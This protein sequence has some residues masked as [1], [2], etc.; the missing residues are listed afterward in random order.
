[1]K[2]KALQMEFL[3]LCGDYAAC[4]QPLGTLQETEKKLCTFSFVFRNVKLQLVYRPRAVFGTPVSTLYC[5][6]FPDKNSPVWLHLPQLLPLLGISDYRACYFPYIETAKRMEVCFRALTSFFEVLYPRL[7]ALAADG[8]DRTLLL[9]HL[10]ESG[11]SQTDAEQVLRFGTPEQQGYLV[12]QN[13]NDTTFVARFTEWSPWKCYLLGQQDKAQRLYAKQKLL[14]YEYGLLDFLQTA[15]G[16]SFVPMQPECFAV[17]DMQAVTSGTEDG[18]TLFKGMLLLYPLCA[19]AGCALMGLL[20]MISSWGTLCWFGPE[21]YM[22]L[23]LGA[24][25]A[26][27][28]G[29][30]LRRQ[31][32]PIMNRKNAAA[33]LEFDDILNGGAVNRFT[34]GTFYAFTAVTMIFALLM[35]GQTVRL[36]EDHGD[37]DQTVFSREVFSYEQIDRVYHIEARY[38]DYGERIERDSYVIALKDGRLIDLDG[39]T[40]P[41]ET[42]EQALPIFQKWGIGVT[43]LDSDR[44]LPQKDA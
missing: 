27:F 42:R 37:L 29:I 17:R 40:T 5:R 44:D 14:P 20:Q 39:Y 31:L 8:A 24:L 6:V 19:A 4:A 28:G 7:E 33:Q 43:E 16:Q 26:L 18:L 23:L 1:M 35:A 11:L 3:R 13:K 15:Q 10:T 21:W 36:Y 30:A 32:M 34:M 22:G 12:Y 41:E 25:P 38:N 2:T 9:R